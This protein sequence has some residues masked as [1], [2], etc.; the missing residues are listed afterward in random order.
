MWLCVEQSRMWCMSWKAAKLSVLKSFPLL[1]WWPCHRH[2]SLYRNPKCDLT[3]AWLSVCVVCCQYCYTQV[4]QCNSIYSYTVSCGWKS[5]T[6]SVITLSYTWI[7]DSLAKVNEWKLESYQVLK[8]PPIS[9]CFCC[10][11]LIFVSWC[12]AYMQVTTICTTYRFLLKCLRLVG[13]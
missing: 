9:R 2:M 7:T 5:A 6:F 12:S 3:L 1:T 11:Q 10:M 13:F 4:T 8:L